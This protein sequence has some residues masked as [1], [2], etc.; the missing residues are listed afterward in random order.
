[1]R[2]LIAV[3]AVSFS[4]ALC[5]CS[6]DSGKDAG[7]PPDSGMMVGCPAPTSGPTTHQAHTIND[8]E[9]WAAAASPHIVTGDYTIGATGQLT[10]EP[11]TAVQLAP[12][13]TLNVN[14][15]L[16]SEGTAAQPITIGQRDTG[17]RWATVIVSDPGSA[18]FVYTT[19]SGGGGQPQSTA[20]NA[21]RVRGESVLPI[22]KPVFVDHLTVTDSAGPGMNLTET[23]GFADGSQNLTITGAGKNP[24]SNPFGGPAPL[25]IN[26][27]AL[28]TIPTGQYTGNGKDEIVITGDAPTYPLSTDATLRDRGVPYHVG[29]GFGAN[30]DMSVTDD[31]GGLATLTIEPNVTLLFDFGDVGD[32]Q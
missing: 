11:C 30:P 19:V 14:G 16:V 2:H 22:V 20:G 17:M 8:A 26:F 21:I 29:G 9:T 18:R 4:V 28:G 23:A 25:R 12:N 15:K 7:T 31:K 32:A 5:G 24:P 13:V 27:N 1:M 6:S 3:S 10:L